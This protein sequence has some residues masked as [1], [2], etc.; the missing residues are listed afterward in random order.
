MRVSHVHD[1]P[2]V[3]VELRMSLGVVHRTASVR[4]S[5]SLKGGDFLRPWTLGLW[6]RAH[7]DALR[8][9]RVVDGNIALQMI[10]PR[11]VHDRS[12]V[13]DG[14]GIAD[15]AGPTAVAGVESPRAHIEHVL[16]C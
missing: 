10:I 5:E 16:Q 4:G 1:L 13:H 9:W 6:R 15:I 11:H 2:A 8:K 7:H 12:R 3:T 14:D